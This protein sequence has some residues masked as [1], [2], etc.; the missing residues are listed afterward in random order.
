MRVL[1]VLRLPN[2]SRNPLV[3]NRSL[4]FLPKSAIHFSLMMI[5]T[6]SR[7]YIAASPVGYCCG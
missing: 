5:A 6:L 3:A 1:V 4:V 2:D 7:Y